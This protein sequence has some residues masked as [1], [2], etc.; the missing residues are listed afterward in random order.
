MIDKITI[1]L[2][3]AGKF[4]VDIGDVQVFYVEKKGEVAYLV[5]H[6]CQKLAHFP[7]SFHSMQANPIP[8]SEFEKI[9]KAEKKPVSI[10]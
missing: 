2:D 7:Q 8:F 4:I 3:D 5:N 10:K 6:Y 9:K 1:S